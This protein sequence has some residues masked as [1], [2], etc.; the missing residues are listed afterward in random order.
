MQIE[1]LAAMYL[2]SALG[3][4][5]LTT[6]PFFF[7]TSPTPSTWPGDQVPAELAAERERLL[8]VDRAGAV[9]AG[10]HA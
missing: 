8:E 6:V 2:A 10:G 1:P 9:E 5:T 4:R 7:V 3:A